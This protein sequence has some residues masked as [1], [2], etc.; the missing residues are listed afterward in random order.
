MSRVRV[1]LGGI[2]TNIDDFTVGFNPITQTGSVKSPTASSGDVS[3]NLTV[4]VGA[5]GVS[6]NPR[7][8]IGQGEDA[9]LGGSLGGT[10][11]TAVGSLFGPAGASAGSFIGSAVG[12]SVGSLFDE[13]PKHPETK[14]RNE[15]L[16]KYKEAGLLDKGNSISSP[17]GTT[18]SFKPG[19]NANDKGFRDY[20]INFEEDLDYTAGMAGI[21]L[22]RL[23]AGSTNKPVDQVGNG[24]G[25]AFLGK[26]GSGADFTPS[27]FNT[28]MSNARAQYSKAGVK[29]KEEML[30]LA[31]TMFSEG[32]INDFDYA[33]MQQTAKLVFDNDFTTA[34]KLMAGRKQG[35]EMAGET[36]SNSSAPPQASKPSGGYPN[37]PAQSGYIPPGYSAP[38]LSPQEAILSVKPFVDYYREHAPK[39]GKG[40]ATIASVVQA[41]GGISGIGGLIKQG[42][43][44][45]NKI[46]GGGLDEWIK[47]GLSELG[48]ALGIIDLPEAPEVVGATYDQGV[49]LSPSDVPDISS[50][51]VSLDASSF[52]WGL[53]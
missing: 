34:S 52:S 46:T 40:A 5:G 13:S 26:A 3:G 51:D 1:G 18:F 48:D 45:G 44:F 31:N 38:I 4:G 14:A 10:A 12:S 24:F 8:Q 35:T 9:Q 39:G 32:R 28:V 22:S 6:A 33:T 20:E 53:S 17:D 25:N 2:S 29:T 50:P 49:D 27:N 36:P 47:Q 37:V 42:Y 16:N 30:A 41:L 15:V 43:D 19:G 7:I 21:S 23:V 11:G